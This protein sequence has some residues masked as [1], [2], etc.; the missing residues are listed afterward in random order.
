MVMLEPNIPKSW[1]WCPNKVNLTKGNHNKDNH[2]KYN[3]TKTTTTKKT[4]TNKTTIRNSTKKCV[5]FKEFC[6]S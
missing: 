3:E 6:L 4:K 1:Y 5:F 2:N